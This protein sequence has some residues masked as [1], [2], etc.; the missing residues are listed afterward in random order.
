MLAI[1]TSELSVTLNVI[2]TIP[3]SLF[4]TTVPSS[5]TAPVTVIG[6]SARPGC[7]LQVN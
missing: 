1:V 4:L 6:P 5:L 7:H 2:V 3:V